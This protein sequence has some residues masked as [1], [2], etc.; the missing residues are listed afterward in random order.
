VCHTYVCKLT[1]TQTVQ[2]FARL[3][4]GVPIFVKFYQ[5]NK[6]VLEGD[7]GWANCC[8]SGHSHAERDEGLKICFE[9]GHSHTPL[10]DRYVLPIEISRSASYSR[11]KNSIPLMRFSQTQHFQCFPQNGAV[12]Q[13]RTSLIFQQPDSVTG[14]FVWQNKYWAV[15]ILQ[16]AG[17]AEK[18]S[19]AAARDGLAKT[20]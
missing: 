2:R 6:R 15:K 10:V 3:T 20:R 5:A 7:V 11:D 17:T 8:E 4:N 19:C 14:G 1:C 16:S 13:K 12:K 9:S 18:H